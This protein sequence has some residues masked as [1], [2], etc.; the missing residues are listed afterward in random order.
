MSLEFPRGEGHS[1]SPFFFLKCQNPACVREQP[2]VL[3]RTCA[4]VKIL[5]ALPGEW[6]NGST[7]DSGS[8]C[9]GSNPSSP[10]CP[11]NSLFCLNTH[12]SNTLK[13]Y[14]SGVSFLAS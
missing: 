7:A 4:P 1:F 5:S 3:S 8:A 2:L 10:A 6:C 12:N 13:N 11:I 14:P 9:L